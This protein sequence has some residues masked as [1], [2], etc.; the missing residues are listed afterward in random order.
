MTE[1]VDWIKK[2][3]VFLI[4]AKMI[5]HLRPKQEYEKYLKLVVGMMILSMILERGMALMSE[6]GVRL[7]EERM[8]LWEKILSGSF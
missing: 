1:L 4:L 6:G 8:I 3:T 5:M 7:W 2:I